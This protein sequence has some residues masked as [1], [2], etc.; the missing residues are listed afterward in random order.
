LRFGHRNGAHFF[1]FW[2]LDT[3]FGPSSSEYEITSNGFIYCVLK[4]IGLSCG[5][6]INYE[7]RELETK[8]LASLSS[9]IDVGKVRVSAASKAKR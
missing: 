1:F 9:A 2:S 5:Y 6:V 4:S 3:L 8:C 7:Y